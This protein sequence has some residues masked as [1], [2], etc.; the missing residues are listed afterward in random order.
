MGFLKVAAV[1]A[2]PGPCER[3]LLVAEQ[4]AL[5]QAFREGREVHGDKGPVSPRRQ[6][7][8]GLSRDFLADAAFAAYEDS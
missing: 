7:V 5:G 1:A 2:A 4:L 3:S 8:N 6:I